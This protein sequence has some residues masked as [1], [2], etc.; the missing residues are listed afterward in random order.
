MEAAERH[1]AMEAAERRAAMEAA[2]RQAERESAEREADRRYE[3]ELVKLKRQ[4]EAKDTGISRPRPENFPVLEKDGDVDAFLRGFEKTCRQYGLAKDQWAQYLTPGLRGK[5][6]EAF[7]DLPPEM[8]GNYEAIKSALLQRFNITPEAHRQ[9]FRDLK[10][11]ASDTYSGLVAQLCA[12]FKQWVGGLQITTFDALQDLMIQE[13]FLTLCPADVKEWVVDRDPASSAEAARLADKYTVTRAPAAKRGTFVPGQS[14]WKGERPGGAPSPAVVSSSFGRVGAK[15][16]QGD[17]RRCF[18]CNRTG[19][20]SAA[21]P[22]RKTSTASTVG[23]PPPRSAP[24]VLCVAGSQVSRNDNLQTVTVGDKVTVGL[25]DTGADVTLVR[26]ELVGS[27]DIIPGKTIAVR[28]VGGIHPAVPMARVYLDWGAGRGLREVGVSDNIPTNVLLGTDLGRML[29]RY[30]ASSDVVD[31]ELNHVF[32]QVSGC[33]RENVCSVVSEVCKLG[34]EK[35]NDCSIVSD[36]GQLSVSKELGDVTISSVSVVTRRQ[37]EKDRSSQL[38]P[39]REVESPSDPEAPPLTPLPPAPAVTDALPLSPDTEQQVRSQAFQQAQQTDTTLET[40]RCLAGSP[41]TESD[42]ER[43]FWEQGR[44]YKESV[45]RDVPEAGVM[46]KRLVVPLMYR[47][48]LLRVAHEVPLAG[49]LGIKKTKSRLKQKFYW[50]EMG[51]D[52]ANYCRSCHACQMVGKPGDV[53]H[54]PLVPLPIIAEPF[55]RVAVDIIGPL[56]IPSSSGKQ[57]ILT[58]VDYATRY[59]EA[60]A[61]SSIRADK[62]A[63]A[64]ISIFS[65]VGFPKEMLT[66]QGTQF[67]SNLMQSLCKKMHV[68]HLIASPY[69]PQTNGLCERFNGTLKQMLRTFVESQG[70][71]WERFLPHLLF[72]YREVPQESTGFSPFELLHGRRVRGPLDLIKED[73]EGKLITP[74]TSVVHYVVQFRERMQSLMGMVHSNLKAAQTKQKQWYDRSARERIFEVGQ[75]VLV[76]VPMRQNKLQA[77]W[78]GPYLIVQ[79]INDVNYVVARDEGRKRHKVY[80]VNMIKAYHERGVSVLAVCSLP[81]GDQEPDPLLDL[82]ASAK[83]G[84]SLETTQRSESLTEVQLD[85]LFVTLRPYQNHFTGKPGQTHLVAHHVN[86]GDQPPLRQTAYRVSLEVQTDMKREIEEMLEL[87]VIRKSH[88]SWAAPVVLIPKKCGGTRFCVDYRRLNEATVFDAYPMPRIDELLERLAHARYITI[89]DLILQAPDFDRRFTVQTD[90]SNYGLGAVLS[91]VNQQGEEHPILYLSRKLLP[92]EVA[93]AVVEKECLAIVWALQKLQSYLYGRDFTVITDHNP[94]SWLHRVAGD[95]GKL[96]RWSLTLQQ[97]TFTV[98][99]RKGSHHGNADGLSR[100]NESLVS[101]NYKQT[102][103]E[104]LELE[105]FIH[106]NTIATKTYREPIDVNSY[107]LSDS[108]HYPQ[109]LKIIPFSQFTRFQRNCTEMD[110]YITQGTRMKSQFPEKNYDKDLINEAFTKLKHTDR[111]QLLEYKSSELLDATNMYAKGNNQVYFV[112]DYSSGAQQLKRILK[113]H[114]HILQK[115]DIIGPSLPKSSG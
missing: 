24:A 40:L 46:E 21:C 43:V 33:D 73:W 45:A 3:L 44:L 70:R 74:E 25:R 51:K 113:K 77:A 59:P 54:A 50:P 83:S 18:I 26:S 53:G 90:A 84:R 49:H 8:D 13:Q 38:T 106:N 6:L 75:K 16:V 68:E 110:D 56:A 98:Q 72:A 35:E 11:S 63:D 32:S 107:I 58:V 41:P 102:T 115:V 29:S 71:D 12:S 93:Y 48:G 57:F 19:H 79:R 39:E 14:A 85:Q 101:A 92:R 78:E 2:E 34:C 17:T 42:K 87:G 64:L 61:L 81:E 112:S 82:V 108:H 88:S 37:A 97:Y 31:S 47:E 62:V 4:S 27:S 52:I 60:V 99:H 66:D 94:L 114:W 80:H 28:G 67:M 1:A 89:M 109:W 20:L 104:F 23:P 96:L 100:Q 76:L 10:R 36:L 22:D 15:P 9:K 69:H 65:R 105:I 103:I 55:E 91:Q 30:V 111:K 5:A 86:T 95:N 7:A